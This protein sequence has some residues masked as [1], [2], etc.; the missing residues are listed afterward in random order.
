MTRCHRVLTAICVAT[1]FLGLAPGKAAAQELKSV[2][3]A[4]EL[5]TLLDAAK[6]ESFAAKGAGADQ[7]VAAL[8]FPGAQLLVVSG[9]YSAPELLEKTIGTKEYREAYA[10]LQSASIRDSKVFITDVGADGLKSK[11][12]DGQAYDT[13]MMDA[14][15]TLFDGDWK[16]QKL[17]EE[18]YQKR[19]TAA[20]A[21]YSAMLTQLL[22]QL[23][24]RS[25]S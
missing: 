10:E 2:A 5:A 8:H 13:Y 21:S 14:A 7:F 12:G 25:S 23:K 3:L 4:K 6:L 11:P 9:K 24:K 17:T 15:R 19:V 22:A 20:D 18:E 1:A 16:K